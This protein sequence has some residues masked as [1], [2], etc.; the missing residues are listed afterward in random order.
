MPVESD[1][2]LLAD[3]SAAARSTPS[4]RWPA[5]TP[6][7]RSQSVELRQLGGALAREA[8]GGGAQAKIDAKYVMFAGGIAPTPRSR[9]TPCARTC[10]LSRRRLAAWRAGHDYYNF[11]ETPAEA[12]AVL[13]DDAYRRLREI[14]AMYDP[15]PGDRLRPP[16][17]AG[18]ALT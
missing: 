1:G 18:R 11:A 4:W 9:A 16:R 5:R 3:A 8:P 14:K 12:D 13:P 17:S 10:G 2:A 6:T 15:G 7:R